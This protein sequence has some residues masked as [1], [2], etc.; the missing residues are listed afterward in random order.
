MSSSAQILLPEPVPVFDRVPHA[1]G[2]VKFIEQGSGQHQLDVRA[3][4]QRQVLL[5]LDP[6]LKG[7]VQG[8]H[9]QGDVVAPGL[10]GAHL[11][12]VHS[13]LLPGGVPLDFLEGPLDE[14]ALHLAAQGNGHIGRAVGLVAQSDRRSG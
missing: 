11:V 1:L 2:R 10:V 6:G 14:I 8:H 7:E 13:Q 12:L 4:E 5:H 9:R 3:G